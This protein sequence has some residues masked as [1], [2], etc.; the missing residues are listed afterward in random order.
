[1][2][3]STT[4][5]HFSSYLLHLAISDVDRSYSDVCVTTDF[6]FTVVSSLLLV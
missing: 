3:D 1:M 4:P 2:R 5:Y 6:P